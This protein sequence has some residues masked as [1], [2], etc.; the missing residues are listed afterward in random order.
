M[1]TL[2]IRSTPFA[3]TA[4]G[5]TVY[6]HRGNHCAA[7]GGAN[8]RAEATKVRDQRQFELNKEALERRKLSD[9]NKGV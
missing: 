1:P 2:E 8:T 5:Y 4:F 7:I 9:A 6:E 3:G